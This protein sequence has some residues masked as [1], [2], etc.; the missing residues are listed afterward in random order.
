MREF[1]TRV[2][3]AATRAGGAYIPYSQCLQPTASLIRN[4]PAHAGGIGQALCARWIAEHANER[5]MWNWLCTPGTMDVRPGIVA[6]LMIDFAAGR[7][8]GSAPQGCGLPFQDAAE[9]Y[10]ARHG[11]VRSRFAPA[12]MARLNRFGSGAALG[13][14]LAR[15]LDPD[16]WG[17]RSVYVLV[18]LVGPGGGHALAAHLGGQEICLFDPNFGEFDFGSRRSCKDFL[19]DFWRASGYRDEFDGCALLDFRRK[20]N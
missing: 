13:A 15:D 7:E 2:R 19:R 14:R 17:G 10:L 16:L 4:L 11:L 20:A 1:V 8:A 12:S 18:S 6:S 3:Q 5:S 9:R